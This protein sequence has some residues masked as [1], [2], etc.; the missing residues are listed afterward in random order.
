MEH[1]H[2]FPRR[3]ARGTHGNGRRLQLARFVKLTAKA[4]GSERPP[5]LVRPLVVLSVVGFAHL[6]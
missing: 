2:R 1:Q 5:T 3:G 4:S 6:G